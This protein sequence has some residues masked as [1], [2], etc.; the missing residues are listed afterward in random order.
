MGFHKTATS[1]FQATCKKN[2][3]KLAKQGFCYPLFNSK[4][5]KHKDI[6][7]HSIPIFSSFTNKPQSYHINIRWGVDNI[8]G[9]NKD[10]LSLLK[11]CLLGKRDIILSGEDISMLPSS[12]LIKLKSFLEE[13]EITIVP[14]VI[15]RSP[16]EFH[17]SATQQI[18]KQGNGTSLTGFVSQINKIKKIQS[19]FPETEFIP[20]RQTCQHPS[21]PVG[22][23]LEK[24]GVCLDPLSMVN[25]N[26]GVSN[27][28]VRA[29]VILNTTSPAIVK[30]KANR[31]WRNACSEGKDFF[32][33]KFL[34]TKDEVNLIQGD[35]DKENVFFK[36]HLGEAFSDQQIR[37]S[38]ASSV[39]HELANYLLDGS[40]LKSD[41]AEYLRDAALKLEDI[42][43]DLSL[44]LMRLA[45]NARPHGPF[46]KK[47]LA[48]Y[49]R[50]FNSNSKPTFWQK[51][52][53]LRY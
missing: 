20:F 10:Y 45:S 25:T 19:V 22:Y 53:R 44:K 33:S 27:A 15:V 43:L 18:V 39:Y 49:E 1:S 26:E 16:Y 52:L 13:H 3:T 12:N 23:L 41:D 8:S 50:S 14:I 7:N 30:G 28:H 36:Q 17:C 31:K 34:L 5:V 2:V 48:E 40:G 46:I 35:L 47:K 11:K 6:D 4:Y 38:D 51:I 32:K 24:M 9:L 29:Q 42:D 21:G 37:C